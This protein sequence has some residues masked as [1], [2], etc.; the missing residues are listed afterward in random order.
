MELILYGPTVLAALAF[1]VGGV[2]YAYAEQLRLGRRAEL[3]AALTFV[4][5]GTALVVLAIL[6][7]L[8]K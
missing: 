7:L 8:L 3:F 1:G 4:G 6:A 5:G 2:I